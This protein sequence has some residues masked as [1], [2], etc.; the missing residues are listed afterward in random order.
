MI[1]RDGVNLISFYLDIG[2]RNNSS[3]HDN[4]VRGDGIV[5]EGKIIYEKTI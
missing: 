4:G 2:I 3:I 1:L 5:G